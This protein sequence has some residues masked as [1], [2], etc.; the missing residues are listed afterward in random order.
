MPWVLRL[1]IVQ[2][3]KIIAVL[4]ADFEHNLLNRTSRTKIC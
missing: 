3:V 4:A 1:Y 2:E